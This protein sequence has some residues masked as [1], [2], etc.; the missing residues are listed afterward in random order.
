MNYRYL[1]QR[2]LLALV[3]IWGVSVAVFLI[4]QLVPGDP[5]RV[6]L[7]VQANEENIAA[8]RERMGLNRPVLEQYVSWFTDVLQGDFGNSLIT[9]QSVS[10][11]IASRL[12]ATIQLAFMSL[13][14]G[15]TVAFPLGIISALYPRS[16]IDVLA[17][18]ISQV[19]VSIPDFWL[20][21]MLILLFS[22]T[23]GW[24]PPSGYNP[25]SDGVGQWLEH[26]I[27]PALTAGL[28]SGSIQTRFIRSAMLEVLNENYIR[29]AY[30]KG[31]RRLTVI[32][33]HA[34]RNAMITIVTIIGLQMTALFSAVV[35]VEIV[36]AFPGLGKLS[37]DAVLDRDYPLLQ[38]TVL[39]FATIVTLINLA[40]DMFYFF[41]DPRIE[42]S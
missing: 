36:F 2:L 12:P 6:V 8:M 33:R 5:A 10:D 34:L 20:G 16:P 37:L 4:I 29:T 31:L 23:L 22:L 1:F 14:V 7:G 39:V 38:G 25:L 26:M 41:L 42:Y 21:I 11:Q 32:Q 27:L 13:L 9:A 3:V 15:L 30:A 18:V 28:I 19:G 17:S 40:V 24:L 35:V